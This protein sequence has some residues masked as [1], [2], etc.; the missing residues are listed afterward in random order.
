MN[1]PAITTVCS[2]TLL[3]TQVAGNKIYW[4]KGNLPTGVHTKGCICKHCL[5]VNAATSK[6]DNRKCHK[7]H[8]RGH[9]QSNC[10]N[11]PSRNNRDNS[12]KKAQPTGITHGWGYENPNWDT[13]DLDPTWFKPTEPIKIPECHRS[14][15]SRHLEECFRRTKCEHQR[16][17]SPSD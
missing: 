2:A 4:I 11:K 13:K 9:L 7:C 15:Y 10:T 5:K 16:F 17:F 8:T 14:D 1:S 3:C 6:K 12:P